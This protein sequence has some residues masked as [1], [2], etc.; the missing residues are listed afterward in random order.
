MQ[1]SYGGTSW[2]VIGGICMNCLGVK[3]ATTFCSIVNGL[4]EP[5]DSRR[6]GDGS[7]GY[8]PL[9]IECIEICSHG[10][11]YSLAHYS[12][13]NG[14]LMRDPELTF[15]H[16]NDGEILPLSYRNDFVGVDQI[17]VEMLEH[18]G[19]KVNAKLQRELMLFSTDWLRNISQ[20]QDLE[21]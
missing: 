15:L 1:Q 13:Q 18:S 14:D 6:I 11:I 16:N 19:W 20:Q 10:L 4:R 21:S 5:G 17:A 3:A 9:S 8:M 12:E 7:N 2:L